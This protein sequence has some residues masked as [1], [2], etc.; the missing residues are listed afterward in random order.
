MWLSNQGKTT[1]SRVG[2]LSEI[3]TILS[4]L[5]RG[6]RFGFELA[7]DKEEAERLMKYVVPQVVT[8]PW[9][10]GLFLLVGLALIWL[11]ERIRTRKKPKSET[12]TRRQEE[13]VR[14]L[15]TFSDA[16]MEVINYVR[17]HST[18]L[19]SQ[20]GTHLGSMGYEVPHRIFDALKPKTTI[21]S[22]VDGMS[23]S[24]G[25][26]PAMKELLDE[27]LAERG[28]KKT[29]GELSRTKSWGV[30][31]VL[32]IVSVGLAIGGHALMM[33]FNHPQQAADKP[34][35][36]PPPAH[37]S[38]SPPTEAKKPF[39]VKRPAIKPAEVPVS[40]VRQNPPQ[41]LLDR[42]AGM[43]QRLTPS[44]KDG[45]SRA[46]FAYSKILTQA[47]ALWGTVGHEL[48][49][50][51]HDLNDGDIEQTIELRRAK[52]KDLDLQAKGFRDSYRKTR[53]EWSYYQEQ[54]SYVLGDNENEGPNALINL[55]EGREE[56]LDQFSKIQNRE[57]AQLRPIIADAEA[58]YNGYG[59]SYIH[60]IQ[61]CNQRLVEM[62]KSIQ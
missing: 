9:F 2:W 57:Q 13:I 48:S 47:N 44:D 31:V 50:M 30:A 53:E 20:I 23:G 40:P 11:D 24:V 46:L 54:A 41:T 33:K 19:P 39:G 51:D 21:I 43:N 12:D 28:I 5:F 16:E 61:E 45:L 38:P 35:I 22:V 17:L 37:E 27:T 60:W 7:G 32:V 52:L 42:V 4:L 15:N 29:G 36:S 56:F 59:S 55:I 14:Q 6:L 25:I 18:V 34:N 1:L 8:A 62:K 58:K 10:T 49:L 3:V 26:N